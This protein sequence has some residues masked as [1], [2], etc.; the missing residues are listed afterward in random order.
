MRMLVLFDLPT[1][2]LKEQREYVNFR[3]FLIKSGFIMMQYSVYSKL[4]LNNTSQSLLRDKIVKN[5]P[6]AGTVQLL[7]ITEKQFVKIEYILGSGQSS[8][9]DSDKRLVIL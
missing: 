2:T 1:Q 4:L 3:K 7:T 8:V 6:S 9:V 5:K